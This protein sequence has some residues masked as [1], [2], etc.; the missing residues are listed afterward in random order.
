MVDNVIEATCMTVFNSVR[1]VVQPFIPVCFLMR[2]LVGQMTGNPDEI[3]QAFKGV[4]L[5]AILFLSYGQ[6]LSFVFEI[7]HITAFVPLKADY[8]EADSGFHFPW[9]DKK[10]PS[11]T[12]EQL[13]KNGVNKEGTDD[14]EKKSSV[15]RLLRLILESIISLFFWGILFFHTVVLF[16][17]SAFAPVIFVLGCVL[18]I[19]ILPKIFF[20]SF[21]IL[22]IW[23][24]IFIGIHDAGEVI[25]KAFNLSEYLMIIVEFLLYSIKMI[26]L[27]VTTASALSSNG[28][29]SNVAGS[30]SDFMTKKNSGGK[31]LSSFFKNYDGLSGVG[32][33]LKSGFGQ[34]SSSFKNDTYDGKPVSHKKQ[35]REAI[36]R[37]IENEERRDQKL[38]KNKD[39]F[40]DQELSDLKHFK[41]KGRIQDAPIDIRKNKEFGKFLANHYPEHL[42]NINSEYGHF[43]DSYLQS[44]KMEMLSDKNKDVYDHIVDKKTKEG[45]RSKHQSP[46]FN[47]YKDSLRLKEDIRDPN[48]TYSQLLS[49]H[50]PEYYSYANRLSKESPM[51][52]Q[53]ILDVKKS[54]SHPNNLE[55]TN[56]VLFR[57]L[58][59]YQDVPFKD[60]EIDNSDIHNANRYNFESRLYSDIRT[61]SQ[62]SEALKLVDPSFHSFVSRTI[63]NHPDYYQKVIDNKLSSSSL[64]GLSY[65][66]PDLYKHFSSYCRN[67]EEELNPYS[68]EFERDSRLLLKDIGTDQLHDQ[69]LFNKDPSFFSYL[70]DLKENYPSYY[71]SLLLERERLNDIESIKNSNPEMY[72]FI[73]NKKS[74]E[75]E[76]DEEFKN[77]IRDRLYDDLVEN[78]EYR[79]ALSVMDR[80]FFIKAQRFAILNKNEYKEVIQNLGTKS[81]SQSDEVNL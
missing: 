46:A 52:Y 53:N 33:H 35:V 10:I 78:P 50:D 55:K 69:V 42:K 20:A 58:N 29:I 64:D 68:P 51:D 15:P 63:E 38:F 14:L 66:H 62:Y 12:K 13:Q 32:K 1:Q 17:M 40:S 60:F 19:G 4:I 27:K 31:S 34:T 77:S 3:K 57:H 65:Y 54:A 71:Q 80:G 26:I 18:G 81:I 48:S 6:I 73:L 2:V 39:A 25:S 7:R 5:A 74:T 30:I 28:L 70:L 79:H 9:E 59:Q 21:A 47:L 45:D 49:Y 16:F 8:S 72:D 11:E 23:P 43:Y 75:D 44:K 36:D 22:S 41:N 67:P 76:T 61:D 24:V 37:S 56:P